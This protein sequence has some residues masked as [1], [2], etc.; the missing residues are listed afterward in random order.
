MFL[1]LND[2]AVNVIFNQSGAKFDGVQ[3]MISGRNT[4]LIQL[5]E[6]VSIPITINDNKS[7]SFPDCPENFD[8]AW[9]GS[10]NDS[11]RQHVNRQMKFSVDRFLKF[12]SDE[13]KYAT[14]F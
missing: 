7:V 10:Y 3:E 12:I 8:I 6:G 5:E 4:A 14:A 9:T 2:E 13:P 11:H 1:N